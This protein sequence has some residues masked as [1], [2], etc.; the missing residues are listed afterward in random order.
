VLTSPPDAAARHLAPELVARLL[1]GG[2]EH[3]ELARDVLP[4]LLALCPCCQATRDRLEDLQRDV[5]HWDYGVALA[6]GPQA[7]TLWRRLEPLAHAERLAAVDSDPAFHSWGLCRLLLAPASRLT[8]AEP[9]ETAARLA[10]LAVAVAGHLGDAYHPSWVRDLRALAFARLGDARRAMG[11]LTSAG[12]AFESARSLS[13]A[14]TGDPALEAEL[15]TLEALLR[16]DQ[17]RLVEASQLL[18]R[19]YAIDTGAVRHRGDSVAADPQR[20][21]RILAHRAWCLHHL[22]QPGPAAALLAEAERLADPERSP[23]LLLAVRLG[24]AWTAIA[25]AD[26]ALAETHLAGA[27]PL[28]T[29]L[30]DLPARLR[31]RRAEAAIASARGQRGPAEQSLLEASRGCILADLGCDAALAFLDLAVLYREQGAADPL[32]L[33]AAEVLPVFSAPDLERDAFEALL[34]FQDACAADRL[35]ADLARQL[36]ARIEDTRAPSLACWSAPATVLAKE[37]DTDAASSHG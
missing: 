25:L 21:A 29:R 30:G 22:G 5:G 8:G 35:T 4:H 3:E 13:Q 32:R 23:G 34:R 1:S 27:D 2:I 31:L 33:L 16:R 36:A 24:R 19:A 9:P 7:P 15:L 12:H 20:A 28:A 10:A 26:L 6:E 17:R 11:E 14:G 37:T 18:D